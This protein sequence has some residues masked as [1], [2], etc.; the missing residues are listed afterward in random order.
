MY[1]TILA[2]HDYYSAARE[3]AQLGLDKKGY[4]SNFGVTLRDAHKTGLGS[5]AA[6]V[7]ALT[8]ALLTH[9]LPNISIEKNQTV[10]HN[11]AQV[12]HCAAQ[13]KIGSGFDI[14]TAVYG[15][16]LYRRFTPSILGGVGEAGSAGFG[17][18]LRQCVDDLDASQKWDA[19]VHKSAIKVPPSLRLIMC[20]VDCGSETPSMVKKLLG[21]RKKN[22]AEADLLWGAIQKGTDDICDQFTRLALLEDEGD[23]QYDELRDIFLTIRSL[24]REMTEKSGVPV[25]PKVQT[26]LLD[27]CSAIPGV[28]GGV[29]PGSGGYDA[30]AL[31][32]K[33]DETVV[34]ALE[35]MLER[36][37]STVQEDSSEKIGHV[38]LLG[39]REEFEGVRTEPAS[40]YKGWV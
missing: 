3:P 25:E 21:W 15:S 31:L 29:V 13:G 14:A 30:I 20:D 22:P 4:F 39:V 9:H 10:I 16:C 12:A 18:R 24:I 11:L 38:R 33:N 34:T 35:G 8:T 19:E 40:K 36:W 23:E 6:L 28:I 17:E 2:D 5:S 7:T 32:V 37:Q 1:I 26:E 27:A